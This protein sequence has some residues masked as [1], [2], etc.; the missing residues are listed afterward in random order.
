MRIAL[1]RVNGCPGM[2]DHVAAKVSHLNW[3]ISIG[4]TRVHLNH[5]NWCHPPFIDTAHFNWGIKSGA[6][7]GHQ[8]WCHPWFADRGLWIW[9]DLGNRGTE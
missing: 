2:R 6:T 7:H 1:K 3:C 9:Q 8:K 5:L 4:A